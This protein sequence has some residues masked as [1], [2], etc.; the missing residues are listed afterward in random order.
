MLRDDA[1]GPPLQQLID[2]MSLLSEEH[3]CAG[4]LID[5]EHE[6]WEFVAA[7]DL[8]DHEWGMGTVTAQNTADMKRLS[9][10]IAG[11]VCWEENGLHSHVRF[12]PMEDWITRHAEWKLRIERKRAQQELMSKL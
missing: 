1:P 7:P 12:I 11:W 8:H 6:L 9:S 4:W 10:E 2:L 3:Y 5:L